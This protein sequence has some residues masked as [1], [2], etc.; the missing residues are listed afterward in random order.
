MTSESGAN[1][2][3]EADGRASPSALTKIKNLFTG[4]DVNASQSIQSQDSQSHGKSM[5]DRIESALQDRVEAEYKRNIK[6]V[7]DQDRKE[8]KLA[9]MGNAAHSQSK[10]FARTQQEDDDDAL[11]DICEEL[12]EEEKEMNRDT[13]LTSFFRKS[14]VQK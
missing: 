8:K 10:L 14:A 13:L 4:K 5:M 7:Y 2:S 1:D 6:K 9:G 12:K 3:V 11:F